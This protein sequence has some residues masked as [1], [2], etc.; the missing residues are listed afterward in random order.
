MNE[1]NIAKTLARNLPISLKQSVEICSFI[2]N[3]TTAKAK[4]QLQQVIKKKLAIPFK[5]YNQDLA[6]KPG[7]ASGR[8]P[9]KASIYF[10]KLLNSLE[11]N[12]EFKN[13]STNLIIT[14]ASASKGNSQF[15][16]GRQRRRKMK[17]THI[18][19]RAMEKEPEEESKKQKIKTTKETQDKKIKNDRKEIHKPES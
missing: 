19:I 15:H 2:K 3:K 8:Y 10:I 12:A 16:F 9:E 17:R 14:Y 13:L 5:R 7:M 1:D 18:E 11:A 6:H 4:S